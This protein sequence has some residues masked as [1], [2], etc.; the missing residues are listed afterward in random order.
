MR[1]VIHNFTLE[2]LKKINPEGFTDTNENNN[3]YQLIAALI[4]LVIINVLL[5]FLGKWL[6]NDFLVN[7]VTIVN[8]IDSIWQLLAVSVLS[9]LILN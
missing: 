4:S 1:S 7:V 8:P 3:K 5:L 9:K 6:W 2:F